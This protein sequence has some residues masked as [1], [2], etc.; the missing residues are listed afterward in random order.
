MG[1]SRRNTIIIAIVLLLLV[2]C[3]GTH[4][5]TKA[6]TTLEKTEEVI[7]QNP[8]FIGVTEKIRF[9]SDG[10]IKPIEM[11]IR[12]NEADAVVT[13]KD[14]LVKFVVEN[15]DTLVVSRKIVEKESLDIVSDTVEAKPTKTSWLGR[16][17]TFKTKVVIW[18]LILNVL[19]IGGKI[20]GITRRVYLPM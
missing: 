1:I 5:V 16:W 17:R 19:F 4:T 2:S 8:Y 13:I 11:R 9:N 7:L 20:Y 15:P 10:D 14:G 3:K 18:S 6:T 12:H